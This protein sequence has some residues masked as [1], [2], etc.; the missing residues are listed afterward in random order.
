M[1]PCNT[2]FHS[3]RHCVFHALTEIPTLLLHRCLKC[4]GSIITRYPSLPTTMTDVLEHSGVKPLAYEVI[5]W[6]WDMFK[7]GFL[8]K[9]MLYNALFPSIFV[10]WAWLLLWLLV[11]RRFSVIIPDSKVHGTKG[12]P[13]WSCLPQMGPIVGPMNLANLGTP[14][15]GCKMTHANVRNFHE[16]VCLVCQY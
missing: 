13:P 2:H 6:K 14:S 9:S 1:P 16:D 3:C 11:L 4:S 7:S 15:N 8:R 10:I 5:T 12:G